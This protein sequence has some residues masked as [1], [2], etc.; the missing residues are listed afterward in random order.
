[1][2]GGVVLWMLLGSELSDPEK[3]GG[4]AA[5]YPPLCFSLVFFLALMDSWGNVS[6]PWFPHPRHL[7]T[8]FRYSV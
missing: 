1:M 6:P 8:L 4:D 3:K 2:R 7:L 5:P